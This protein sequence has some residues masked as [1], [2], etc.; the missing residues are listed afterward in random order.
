M[1]TAVYSS[2]YSPILVSVPCLFLAPYVAT[3][4][5]QLLETEP[6]PQLMFGYGTVCRHTSTVSPTT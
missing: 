2:N 3:I 4:I 6:S 1:W 5:V